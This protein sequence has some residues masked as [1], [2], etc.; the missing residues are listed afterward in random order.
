VLSFSVNAFWENGV[1]FPRKISG[2]FCLFLLFAVAAQGQPRRQQSWSLKQVLKQLDREAKTFHTLSAKV[3]RTKVTVVVND[4]STESGEIYVR[5]DG[6]L[7]LNLTKPDRRTILRTGDHLYIYNPMISQV[8]EY[9]LSKHREQI[10]QFLLLGFGNSAHD[11]KKAY[12][13]TLHGEQTLDDRKTVVLELTP[14]SQEVRN[15]IAKIE[16][17]IDESSWLPVQQKFYEAGTQDY[18]II[19]YTN[20]VRNAPLRGSLFKPHWPKG[21]RKVKPQG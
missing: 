13:M 21:T 2:F 9:D 15:Q 11:L 4:R 12:L 18:F 6:K 8:E 10:D 16:L 17:W 20:I 3:E 1:N 7:R 5:R 19:R 14:K